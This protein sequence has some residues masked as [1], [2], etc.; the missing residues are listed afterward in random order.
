MCLGV[1]GEVL[2]VWGEEPLTRRARVSFGGA[3]REF[4][5]QAPAS[6]SL[7]TLDSP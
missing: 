1:P 2:E 7:S 6:T 5:T 3:V 4:P